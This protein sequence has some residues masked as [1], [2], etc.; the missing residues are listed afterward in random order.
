MRKKLV[1]LLICVL[2][3]FAFVNINKHQ[4]NAYNVRVEKFVTRLYKVCLGRTPD[5]NGVNEWCELLVNQ[6][7]T[8]ASVAYGFVNSSEFINRKLS[9]SDYVTC[10]YWVF[11]ERDPDPAG[12]QAWTKALDDGAS[13]ER[14]FCGFANSSEFASVCKSYGIIRGY[15]LEGYNYAQVGQVNLFVDRLYKQIL[16]RECDPQGMAEWTAVLVNHK[17]SGSGVAYGFVFSPEFT[18][19]NLCNTHYVEVLYKAFLGRTADKAGLDAWVK[20][21]DEGGC[22]EQVFNGFAGSQEFIGICN[23]YGIDNGSISISNKTY[24]N[25]KCSKCGV[26]S[27]NGKMCDGFVNM[28]GDIYYFVK[29]FQLFNWQTINDK[30]YYFDSS[31]GKMAIG[32]KKFD[33]DWYYFDDNGIMKTG[34]VKYK[35]QWYY[36][37]E[38]GHMRTGWLRLEKN[39]VDEKYY[40]DPKTGAAYSGWL[41]EDGE[42]YYFD[43]D[44]DYKMLHDAWKQIDGKWYYFN[45]DGAMAYSQVVEWKGKSYYL[46]DDGTMGYGWLFAYRWLYADPET[47]VL[48]KDCWKE[49]KG[50]YYYFDGVSLVTNEFVDGYW[51]DSNGVRTVG[52]INTNPDSSDPST[53][54]K[55]IYPDTL[56]LAKGWSEINGKIYYFYENNN[57]MATG[58]VFL[59]GSDGKRHF[60]YFGD[61]GAAKKGWQTINGKTAYFKSDYTE[62]ENDIYN[63]D[64]VWYAFANGRI[65]QGGWYGGYQVTEG[66]VVIGYPG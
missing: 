49:I 10:M 44:N 35:E 9:N 12:L 43:I 8:G 39:G 47:G 20:A 27:Y 1:S 30:K 26:T 63:V 66:G 4:V 11:F 24:A 46:K 28:N 45:D 50:K 14:V 62:V 2:T 54:W 15:H 41:V 7:A 59:M 40:L 17:S 34:W 42:K 5:R 52:W 53:Y 57:Y 3:I 16:G 18:N 48:A 6:K 32:W 60:Y 56:T 19:K 31:S 65:M 58:E 22:R 29:G 37:N 38:N 61:D 36:L 25:G 51:V 64:G 33:D 13:R 55:Y 21:L 23:S